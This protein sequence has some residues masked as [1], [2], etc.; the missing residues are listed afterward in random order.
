MAVVDCVDHNAL[1][2]PA[3]GRRHAAERASAGVAARRARRP[4]R[5][6]ARIGA[7]ALPPAVYRATLVA[8]D[9]AGNRSLVVR[10]R[11]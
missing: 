8:T 2:T 3:G 1:R 10:G 6:A 5:S 9:V 4:L 7:S 11:A